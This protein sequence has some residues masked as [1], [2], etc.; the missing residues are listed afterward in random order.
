MRQGSEAKGNAGR[1]EVRQAGSVALRKDMVR[2]VRHDEKKRHGR[3]GKSGDRENWTDG[4]WKRRH[5]V[6]GNG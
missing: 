4:A 6:T 5:G 3:H 2:R 1:V